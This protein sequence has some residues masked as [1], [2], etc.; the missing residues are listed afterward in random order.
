MT[1]SGY[2]PLV[3]FQKGTFYYISLGCVNIYIGSPNLFKPVVSPSCSA[4]RYYSVIELF[5]S[6]LINK[7]SF[8]MCTVMHVPVIN[9][10][11]QVFIK[12]LTITFYFECTLANK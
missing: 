8:K 2:H 1:P 10:T 4:N 7:V 5:L 12:L 6:E 9:F 3:I 11:K